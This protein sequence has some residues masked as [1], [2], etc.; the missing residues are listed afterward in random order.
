MTGDIR[1]L[2]ARHLPDYRVRSIN[3]L[4]HGLDN[5]VYEVNDELLVRRSR[6]ADPEANRQEVARLAAVRELSPLPVPEVVFAD[7]E[8]GT[9]AYRKL[10]GTPLNQHRN[11]NLD[12]ARL[13]GPLGAFL[14][15]IHGAIPGT[16]RDL[17]PLDVY[18]APTLL[19]DAALD[20]RDVE[21]HVPEAQRPLVERFLQETPPDEPRSLRFC[22][23]DLGAEHVLVDA[24]TGTITGIID[25]T[26]AA[27]TDPAHDFALIYRD[28]G[29]DLLDRTL[30]HYEFPLTSEDRARI[31]FYAR[32]ALIEDLAYGLSTGPRH[33]ADAALSH[34]AWTFEE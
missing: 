19:Q 33:Y 22:H 24:G 16:M 30:T 5:F 27:I 15:A 7:D 23:N 12:P 14:S 1:A 4:G 21:R 11:G 28:L 9:I 6:V 13:A 32:C 20:Y 18:P 31:R 8:T 10:P 26:D 34:L 17:A 2:L 29:P 25:W 3:R